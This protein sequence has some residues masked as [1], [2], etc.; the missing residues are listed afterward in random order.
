MVSE[1]GWFLSFLHHQDLFSIC[2]VVFNSLI[3]HERNHYSR[4]CYYN[5]YKQCFLCSSF[6]WSRNITCSSSVWWGWIQILKKRHITSSVS[7]EQ[8][9]LHW[10]KLCEASWSLSISSM[11]EMWWYGYFMDFELSYKRDCGQ[12]WICQQFLWTL[13][14]TRRQ[15]RPNKWCEVVSNSEKNWWS[16]S[17]NFRHYCLLHKAEEALGR[18]EHLECK[19]HMHLYMYLWCQG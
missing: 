9:S 8:A 3:H 17:R 4:N 2:F 18:V 15:V 14:G 5:W 1:Q 10:W 7:E 16:D 6:R 11:A 19:E 13:E 12:C